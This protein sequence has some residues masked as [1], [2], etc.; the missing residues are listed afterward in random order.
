MLALIF[1]LLIIFI[2]YGMA[3]NICFVAIYS[4]T[5]IVT[6]TKLIL[7]FFYS[8]FYFVLLISGV[9]VVVNTCIS[10]NTARF[11]AEIIISW[12][13]LRLLIALFNCYTD[14]IVIYSCNLFTHTL[15]YLFDQR[16]TCS[17][18]V[19]LAIRL[20]TFNLLFGIFYSVLQKFEWVCLFALHRYKWTR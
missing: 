14:C 8:F 15:H 17:K 3:T 13:I 2:V 18:H 12:I 19:H 4:Y 16:L 5:T 1:C 7:L 20:F 11:I 10:G 9:V 6:A